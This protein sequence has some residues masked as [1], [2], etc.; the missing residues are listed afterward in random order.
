MHVFHNKFRMIIFHDQKTLSLN[1]KS[2]HLQMFFK[3]GVLNE[4]IYKKENPPQVF[5]CKYCKIFKNSYF[6]EHLRMA[7][8]ALIITYFN[9]ELGN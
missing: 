3:I 5:S 4:K 2:S 7:A 1:F 9:H 6:E 8:S